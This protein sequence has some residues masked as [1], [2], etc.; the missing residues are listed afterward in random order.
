[1]LA[2]PYLTVEQE[3]ADIVERN[4]MQH[5][6]Y[7]RKFNPDPIKAEQVKQEILFKILENRLHLD[8]YT[9][10]IKKLARVLALREGNRK[11]LPYDVYS[12]EG[13]ISST[14]RILRTSLDDKE[15]EDRSRLRKEFCHLYLKYDKDF[16]N[17]SVLFNSEMDGA[18]AKTLSKLRL[19]NE[20][21]Y[22]DVRNLIE[23]YGVTTLQYL[24]VF[25]KDLPNLRDTEVSEN[26]KDIIFKPVRNMNI[27]DRVVNNGVYT[28]DGKLVKIDEKML[29]SEE[30]PDYFKWKAQGSS[31]K[32]QK[33]D[34][35]PFMEYLYDQIYVNEGVDTKHIMWCDSHYR[36][37]T[38][39][40]DYYIDEN[41]EYFIN[42]CRVELVAALVKA[43]VGNVIA[44]SPDNIYFRGKKL[45]YIK[46]NVRGK[47]IILPVEK[48]IIK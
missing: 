16:A 33:I 26:H 36:L 44:I 31:H 48:Y 29:M 38:P 42:R 25:L 7:I 20:G 43:S 14:F 6:K 23:E 5:W 37:T 18:D 12:P 4:I 46:A 3:Q 32:I 24:G 34:C 47:V 27:L 13:E 2:L 19:S 40:G 21:L 9:P 1:M 35:T 28:E 22:S 15:M 17:L 30:N 41:R 45:S 39:A 10:Y 8:D 11:E